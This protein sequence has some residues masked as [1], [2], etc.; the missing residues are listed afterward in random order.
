MPSPTSVARGR[1]ARRGVRQTGGLVRAVPGPRELQ[2]AHHDGARPGVR[3]HGGRHGRVGGGGTGKSGDGPGV[4]RA[5][6]AGF[7]AEDRGRH[8]RRFPGGERVRGRPGRIGPDGRVV[9]RA[10]GRPDRRAASAHRRSADGRAPGCAA[11]GPAR[12][13]GP[14]VLSAVVRAGQAVR[15]EV[16]QVEPEQTAT[17]HGLLV[18]DAAVQDEQL[19]V[20]GRQ[21]TGA[22]TVQV[23]Y[24]YFTRVR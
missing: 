12:R 18:S 4:P 24:F 13:Q 8:V 22:Q 1:R 20:A 19:R 21:K 14:G 5:D 23:F 15:A 11:M 6:H 10:P 3:R 17:V 16:P 7:R 9:R 2:R